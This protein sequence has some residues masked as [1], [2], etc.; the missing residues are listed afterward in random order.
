MKREVVN[1]ICMKSIPRNFFQHFSCLWLK[2][3]ND[4][5]LSRH[6]NLLAIRSEARLSYWL[7]RNVNC[8]KNLS[9]WSVPKPQSSI[10]SSSKKTCSFFMPIQI[11]KLKKLKIHAFRRLG[12]PS[13]AI[14]CCQP[15]TKLSFSHLRLQLLSICHL[16]W[17][18]INPKFLPNQD[19]E[20][21]T[22]YLWYQKCPIN[23]MCCPLSQKREGLDWQ[24]KTRDL[25]QNRCVWRAN[26]RNYPRTFR[27]RLT[28]SPLPSLPP[29]PFLLPEWVPSVHRQSHTQ[30]SSC[31]LLPSHHLH[32]P[33]NNYQSISY[34]F[35]VFP[36]FTLASLL[37]SIFFI[38]LKLVFLLIQRH[39]CSQI[40]AY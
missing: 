34:R 9:I 25:L 38:Y 5:I 21:G 16:H 20:T 31:H 6:Y 24:E 12:L 30:A 39:I 28:I 4:S 2:N 33:R 11:L 26:N 17:T 14:L 37:L 19:F 7:I 35:L 10:R 1:W 22:S 18:C 32:L 15:L 36:L 27:T 3:S 8:V 40:P 13:Y 29:I 23:R